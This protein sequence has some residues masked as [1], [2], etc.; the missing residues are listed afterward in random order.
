[1]SLATEEIV[2][3]LKL[4]DADRKLLGDTTFSSER[5]QCQQTRLDGRRCWRTAHE[6]WCCGFDGP[7]VVVDWREVGNR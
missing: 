2:A 1:M 7:P 5:E 4:R 3:E 6:D